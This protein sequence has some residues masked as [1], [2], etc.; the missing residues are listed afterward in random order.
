MSLFVVVAYLF[1]C[2]IY[3]YSYRL[4]R[5]HLKL[6]CFGLYGLLTH[7]ILQQWRPFKQQKSSTFFR[8]ALVYY[9]PKG[10][11]NYRC[12]EISQKTPYLEQ[13]REL[14]VHKNRKQ[15]QFTNEK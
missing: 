12:N 15:L 13:V 3:V 6:Y 7:M 11:G 2:S 1:D 5:L 4:I 10:V 9:E 14:L 8:T